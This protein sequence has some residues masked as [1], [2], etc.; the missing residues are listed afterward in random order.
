M[1]KHRKISR[2]TGRK[3][4]IQREADYITDCAARRDARVVTI[5][6]LLFFSTDT[7]DAWALEP[8]NGMA[9]CLARDGKRL[10][11]GIQETRDNFAVEWE[12]LNSRLVYPSGPR[13]YSNG[14]STSCR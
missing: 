13:A 5:G 7:G 10:P 14:A 11:S 6:P 12:A 8:E 4:S 1:K 3:V 2:L 9:R